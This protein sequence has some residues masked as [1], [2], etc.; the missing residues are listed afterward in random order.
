MGWMEW[1]VMSARLAE[2]VERANPP[3]PWLSEPE[4]AEYV[5]K[6]P[7]WLRRERAK[8]TLP[9]STVGRTPVYNREDLDAFLTSRRVGAV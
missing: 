5:C 4:A 9:Y 8:G 7:R 3:R 6:S 2:A 1:S